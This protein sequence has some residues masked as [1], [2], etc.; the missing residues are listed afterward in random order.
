MSPIKWQRTE[1]VVKFDVL[2]G[3]EISDWNYGQSFFEMLIAA[4]S[5]LT[6]QEIGNHDNITKYESVSSLKPHWGRHVMLTGPLGAVDSIWPLPWRRHSELRSS[7]EVSFTQADKFG[8]LIEG[9]IAI[10]AAFDRKTGWLDLFK[11]VCDMKNAIAGFVHIPAEI[12]IHK[13]TPGHS[14][15][16]F[17]LGGTIAKNQLSN[18]AWATYFGPQFANETDFGKLSGLGYHVEELAGGYLLRMSDNIMDC[19]NDFPAFSRR[20]VELK[21]HFRPD[22]FRITEEAE[23]S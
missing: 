15:F 2:T 12:E 19:F 9:T 7:G 21:K 13:T 14:P 5:R 11:N 17:P 23:V 10:T 1:P 16:Y 18:L 20:R 6:P 22:L 8:G 3:N 4:D